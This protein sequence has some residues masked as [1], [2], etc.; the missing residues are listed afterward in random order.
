MFFTN[1][2]E[3][4][5]DGRL[6][7]DL[8]VATIIKSKIKN[9]P[10]LFFYYLVE[11]YETPESL[12]FDFY[13]QTHYNYIIMLMNDIVDPFYDWYIPANELEI[14][15]ERKY[16]TP[17]VTAGKYNTDGYFAIHHWQKDTTMYQAS[18]SGIMIIN[19]Q[20]VQAPATAV[21]APPDAWAVSNFQYEE[22]LNIAKRKIKILHEEYVGKINQE[23][24]IIFNNV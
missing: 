8:S 17:T 11:D 20:N 4:V 6:M 5:Y 23:L 14:Y 9:N 21:W 19:G 10:N 3:I 7:K 22:E 13:G 1:F 18:P 2:P 24:E 16:G 15:C 12:A